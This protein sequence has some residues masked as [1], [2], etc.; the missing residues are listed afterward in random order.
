[1]PVVSA[2]Q[3]TKINNTML[4]VAA[5]TSNVISGNAPLVVLFTD[6]VTGGVPTSWLWNFGDGVTESYVVDSN[7]LA[8]PYATHTYEK[9]G[10]Y[11][12]TLYLDNRG[13]KLFPSSKFCLLT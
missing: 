3:V 2:T 6:T 4:P 7:P 12:V 5:F 8:T 1:M 9:P 10:K 11:S 13:G